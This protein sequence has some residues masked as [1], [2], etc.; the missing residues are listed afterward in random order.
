MTTGTAKIRPVT[1]SPE[2]QEA[3]ER[4]GAWT[5]ARFALAETATVLVAELACGLPGCPPLET[6]V[7]FWTEDAKR[8]QFKIFKPVQDV[9]IDDLPFAWLM[10]SLAVPDGF[11]CDCC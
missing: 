8:H 4:V 7:A 11:G 6:V 9:T 5:R 1:K 3:V 2:R 10:D